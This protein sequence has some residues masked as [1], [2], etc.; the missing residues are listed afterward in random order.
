M[1]STW[2]CCTSSRTATASPS[3]GCW[4]PGSG[5]AAAIERARAD[6]FHK[7]SL[8][9]FPHNDTGIALYRRFGFV[10]EGRRVQQYRRASG[11][12][13]DSIVMGLLL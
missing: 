12:L 8:E 4:S 7:L 1:T 13:W 11:E 5:A 9:V 2:G 10:E 6:G 3:W